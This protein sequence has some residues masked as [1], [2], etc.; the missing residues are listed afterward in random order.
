VRRVAIPALLFLALI[1]G[2]GPLHGQTVAADLSAATHLSFIPVPVFE[3]SDPV[4]DS[5]ASVDSLPDGMPL[6]KRLLWGRN[7]VVRVV[8]LAPDSREEELR[9]RRAMLQWHQRT[10]LATWLAMTAQT[11]I[12]ARMYDDL[13]GNYQRYRDTHRR[14]GYATF[15]LYSTTAALQL[16]APPAR[17]YDDGITNISVHRALSYVHF[18]GMMATPLLGASATRADSPEAYQQALDRHR[19]VGWVTYAAFSGAILSIFIPL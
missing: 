12:G 17:E 3:W 8:G 6:S 10:G 15:A 4:G 18:A 16:A 7:G 14:L 19:L 9:L 2:A 1:V 13:P 5:T 11:A